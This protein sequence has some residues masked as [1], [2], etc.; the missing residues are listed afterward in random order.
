MA[1]RRRR[2]AAETGFWTINRVAAM[3]SALVA[4]FGWSLAAAFYANA[5]GAWRTMGVEEALD[6]AALLHGV[7]PI[8]PRFYSQSGHSISDFVFNAIRQ[9][10]RAFDVARWS[11]RSVPWLVA[12][13]CFVEGLI[14][15]FWL[16]SRKLAAKWAE[17]DKAV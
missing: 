14:V 9:L 13:A 10:P 12:G 6:D 17:I 4:V 1:N 7:Q 16:T 11:I 8:G 3:L 5:D 15:Y 2:P